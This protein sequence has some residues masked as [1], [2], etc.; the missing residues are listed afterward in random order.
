MKQ[1]QDETLT[2]PTQGGQ[3]Q[4]RLYGQSFWEAVLWPRG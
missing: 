4:N 2:G 3:A 1:E